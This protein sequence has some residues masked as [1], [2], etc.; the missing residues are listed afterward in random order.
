MEDKEEVK[1]GEPPNL[2]VSHRLGTT[3]RVSMSQQPM[4]ASEYSVGGDQIVC[5]ATEI[6]R[7]CN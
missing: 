1:S 4:S 7:G 3:R 2:N 6:C 5:S